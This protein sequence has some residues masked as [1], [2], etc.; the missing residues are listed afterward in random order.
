MTGVYGVL[1]EL[2]GQVVLGVHANMVHG[3]HGVGVHTY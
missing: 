2:D 1:I 3:K